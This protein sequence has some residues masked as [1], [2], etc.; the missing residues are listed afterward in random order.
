LLAGTNPLPNNHF[1]ASSDAG[2][3]FKAH[4]ARTLDGITGFWCAST[5]ERDASPPTFFLQVSQISANPIFGFK[6]LYFFRAGV[7]GSKMT[8]P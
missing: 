7:R 1:T 8:F 4:G 6:G 3:T 5:T 2:A